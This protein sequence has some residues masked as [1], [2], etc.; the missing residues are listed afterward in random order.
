MFFD[1]VII[2]GGVAGL[3]LAHLLGKHGMNC[4]VVEAGSASP[5]G[6]WRERSWYRE[7]RDLVE[8]D[9]DHPYVVEKSWVKALGGSTNAWEGYCL[10]LNEA[11]FK[12]KTLYGIGFDWPIT[13]D[14]LEP[15]YCRAERY[16]GVAGS[17]DNP[18]DSYRSEKYPL[19]GFE[20][21]SYERGIIEKCDSLGLAWH[22][23]PQARNSIAYGKRSI[24]IFEGDCNNCFT[25][26]RW[27][28]LET[29][30]PRIKKMENIRI[31]TDTTCTHLETDNTGQIIKA[32]LSSFAQEDWSIEAKYFVLSAGAVETSRL[33]LLSRG[34]YC[35]EG[36]A[37]HN[38]LVGKYY[39]D[40]PV[41]RVR[42]E[43]NWRKHEQ[44]QTNILASSHNHRHYDTERGALGFLVNLNSRI[45]LPN[46]LVAAHF[47]MPPEIGNSIT[48]SS[49]K[50]DCFGS[51]VAK[52]NIHA[53]GEWLTRTEKRIKKV[54]GEIASAAGGR[55]LKY[56][57]LQL[58]ACHPMGGCRM[59]ASDADSV[60]DRNLRSWESK[61]LYILST[62][63]FPT[64]GAIN[65]TLTL[66][67]LSFRL[68]EW[69][70]NK[71]LN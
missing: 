39:M 14:E 52:L 51:P 47:E 55:N 41:Y 64:C 38:S 69:L 17:A 25:G 65:P 70:T 24:C 22:H 19:P 29:L 31:F 42:A 1:T 27:N 5:I 3:T 40:H 57:P 4:A 7:E 18:F 2:G 60:V 33:L 21:C 56:D 66:V 62:A 10:R 30:V 11:D 35:P 23:V 53:N 63:V 12:M 43:T 58:W 26:A 68:S 44:L 28:P 48:L 45:S 50:R 37:N 6:D 59:G 49:D 54:I 71:N 32:N 36:V 34:K 8:A 46:I 13:Y 9:T 16:L 15:Y 67:S 61:N 20:F